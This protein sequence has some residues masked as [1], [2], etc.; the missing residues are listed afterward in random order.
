M[1]ELKC[2]NKYFTI[3]K[4]YDKTQFDAMLTE[5]RSLCA[6]HKLEYEFSFIKDVT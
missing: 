4:R 6:E 2:F 3:I 1:Y 5:A